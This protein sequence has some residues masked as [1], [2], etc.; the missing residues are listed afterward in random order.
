MAEKIDG[1]QNGI[2]GIEQYLKALDPGH[3][4]VYTKFAD[5]QR[6]LVAGH[7]EFIDQIAALKAEVR[8]R[9]F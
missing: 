8:L 3:D 7:N 2:N 6:K 9:P 4:A 5:T 1:Y